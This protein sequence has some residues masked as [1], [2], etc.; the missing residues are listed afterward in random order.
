[1]LQVSFLRVDA[2]E[3]AEV[4]LE[5]EV[6]AVPTILF[7]A[8]GKVLERVEGAKVADVTKKVKQLSAKDVL[9]RSKAQLDSSSGGSSSSKD[10][11]TRLKELTQAAPAM[12]FM[13]GAD[14]EI[15]KEIGFFWTFIL[16]VSSPTFF[17]TYFLQGARARQSAVFHA[18]P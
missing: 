10:L 7:C 13:K 4:S 9:S 1:M 15:M 3:I 5:Y 6:A 12:L 8:H 2:E 16:I 14:S 11:N 17:Y 18:R